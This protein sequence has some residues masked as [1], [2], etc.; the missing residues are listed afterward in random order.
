[1]NSEKPIRDQAER[2]RKRVEKTG[3]HGD[4]R[5]T[6]PPRS[7]IHRQKQKKTNAK[8][9]YPVIRLMAL[10]FV[11]L[12]VIFF[13]SEERRVGKEFSSRWWAYH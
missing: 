4:K 2:L 6:L 9:K 3:S 7:E 1:M 5:D 12:P 13:R 10:F 8:I 11:L